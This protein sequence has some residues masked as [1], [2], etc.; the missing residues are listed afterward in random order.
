[1]AEDPRTWPPAPVLLAV[2][3]YPGL[4]MYYSELGWWLGHG[5]E[6][7]GIGLVAYAIGRI[8]EVTTLAQPGI[9]TSDKVIA[10]VL[11]LTLGL[12][13]VPPLAAAAPRPTPATASCPFRTGWS[14]WGARG[15]RPAPAGTATRRATARRIPTKW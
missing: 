13:A 10:G 5:W 2:S 14:S 3:L 6:L 9:E 11:A 15:R 12:L 1:M 7:V 4:I 8:L